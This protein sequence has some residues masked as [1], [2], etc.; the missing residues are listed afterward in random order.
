V[1]REGIR[2]FDKAI[3]Q[4]A[5]SHPDYVIFASF[6][7]A[8]PAMA[9]RLLAA[10]GSQ[11]ERYSS[12]SQLQSFS[13]IAPVS[14]S[15]GKQRW[16]HFRWSCPKFLRQTFH[17]YAALSIQFCHWAREFYD[18]QKTRG[19]THHA[20]VR[21]LAFQ[22]DSHPLPLLAIAATLPGPVL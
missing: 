21:S 17:E 9:P 12:A 6:P 7:G 11:R 16:I 3:S 14:E 1:L 15:S 2:H 5:E 19:K 4:T 8:G 20:A 22:V 13:G 10:F 18:L